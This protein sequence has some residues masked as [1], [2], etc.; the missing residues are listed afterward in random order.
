MAKKKK[1]GYV[2][3]GVSTITSA[4][5]IGGIPN[6]GGNPAV[7]NIQNK[8]MEGYGNV[9]ST[10]PAQGKLAGAGMVMGSLGKLNKKSKKLI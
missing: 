6:V 2:S 10:Y 1:K 5:V 4:I 7:T 8:A 3:S 9:A